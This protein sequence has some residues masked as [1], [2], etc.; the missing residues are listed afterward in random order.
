ML[1]EC[2]LTYLYIFSCLL[3]SSE[4]G[5]SFCNLVVRNGLR[6][7]YLFTEVNI[8]ERLMHLWTMVRVRF[9][10]PLLNAVIPIFLALSVLIFLEKIFFGLTTVWVKVFKLKP[11]KRY[12]WEAIKPDLESGSLA[13]PMVLVQIPMFNEKEVSLFFVHF[14]SFPLAS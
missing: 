8:A 13:F 9:I 3:V 2:R 7:L 5:S 11:K 12:K 6:G 4:V 10:A 14:S 1:V